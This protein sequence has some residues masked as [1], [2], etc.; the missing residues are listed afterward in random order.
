MPS[1]LFRMPFPDP[2]RQDAQLY[3][4]DVEP[5]QA[6]NAR[7]GEGMPVVRAYHVRQ[8][9]F[10]EG[11]LKIL[12]DERPGF[13]GACFTR[14]QVAAEV[15]R[16]GEW[17]T[18]AAVTQAEPALEVCAPDL[19]NAADIRQTRGVTGRAAADFTGCDQPFA[20]EQAADGA[21]GR[22]VAGMA[23]VNQPVAQ[24]FWSPVRVGAAQGYQAV[25][26]VGRD[27]AG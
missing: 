26:Q 13:T 17:P 6:G 11:P 12:A 15:I 14:Q 5:A 21:G 16:Q 25:C 10:P 4:P 20:I 8:P 23:R 9:V 27:N 3:Q 24:F 19:I 18:E 1:V 22:N 2:F 7:T